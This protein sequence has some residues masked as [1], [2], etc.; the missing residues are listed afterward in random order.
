[1]AK[2][3][4]DKNQPQINKLLGKDDVLAA[5]CRLPPAGSNGLLA[6]MERG[7][8]FQHQR[9]PQHILVLDAVLHQGLRVVG[10]EVI[11][12]DGIDAKAVALVIGE[13]VAEAAGAEFD[14]A[15]P[16]PSQVRQHEAQQAGADALPLAIGGNG[17]IEDLGRLLPHQ[18]RHTGAHY[19]VARQGGKAPGA[20]QIGGNSLLCGIGLQQQ[21]QRQLTG[22]HLD[23]LHLYFS[24]IS[25]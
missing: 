12:D 2:Q 20:G 17:D 13:L 4:A 18:I 16:F 6:A 11:L 3:E 21:R 14:A 10:K 15:Y 5:A 8:G 24:V 9:E 22:V 23:K 1:M 19:L 25:L 7:I